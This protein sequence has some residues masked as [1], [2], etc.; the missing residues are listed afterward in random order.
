MKWNP[1]TLIRNKRKKSRLLWGSKPIPTQGSMKIYQELMKEIA[2]EVL[3]KYDLSAVKRI[4]AD[5]EILEFCFRGA[6][7]LRGIV[8]R[9]QKKR[10][11]CKIIIVNALDPR[12][13]LPEGVGVDL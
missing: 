7:V 11:Q 9:H 3:P 13:K 8:C 2:R 6:C 1:F 4:S 10:K 5:A 12:K